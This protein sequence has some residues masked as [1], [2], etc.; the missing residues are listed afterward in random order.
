M[1]QD[2]DPNS[3]ANFRK[4]IGYS[5]I[6]GTRRR[7]AAGMIVNKNDRRSC[8]LDGRAEHFA[9]MHKRSIKSP[10]GDLVRINKLVL[11]IQCQDVELLLKTIRD[12]STEMLLTESN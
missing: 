4:T 8:I 12:Q 10:D 7:V 11:R 6:F 1:I 5:N 9:G 2:I 3:L